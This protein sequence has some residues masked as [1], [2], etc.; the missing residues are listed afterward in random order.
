[1]CPPTPP[2]SACLV[3]SHQQT[4]FLLDVVSQGMALRSPHPGALSVHPARASPVTPAPLPPVPPPPI[5][6]PPAW[7]LPH[8]PQPRLLFPLIA[9][10]RAEAVVGPLWPTRPLPGPW[11]S[12]LGIPSPP[13]TR[14]PQLGR[15]GLADEPGCEPLR[16]QEDQG[17]PPVLTPARCTGSP[18]PRVSSGEKG[19]PRGCRVSAVC[20][21]TVTG[22]RLRP[23]P[24]WGMVVAACVQC[25]G[26]RPAPALQ[27]TCDTH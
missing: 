3:P 6:K 8:I 17:A 15:E 1:M 5:P 25:R 14:C 23:A 22:P 7:G 27:G 12:G 18:C 11:V 13:L 19:F 20:P 24:A 2:S 9:A 21:R 4:V 16:P 26:P 10:L